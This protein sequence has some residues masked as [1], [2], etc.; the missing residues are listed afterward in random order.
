MSPSRETWGARLGTGISPRMATSSPSTSAH[1]SRRRAAAQG[2][3][4]HLPPDGVPGDAPCPS[5]SGWGGRGGTHPALGL[6]TGTGAAQGAEGTAPPA[7]GLCP[8][9]PSVHP[10]TASPRMTGDE[11]PS[12]PHPAIPIAQHT[13]VGARRS[14]AGGSASPGHAGKP[15]GC[16]LLAPTFGD[17]H[18][19][20]AAHP[21]RSLPSSCGAASPL[22]RARQ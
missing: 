20:P 9:S 4:G 12:R 15:W 6:G 3:A 22:P 5:P 1:S 7:M 10:S 11:A 13:R 19:S 14:Q 17:S 8:L 2:H 16:L 21:P 18:P